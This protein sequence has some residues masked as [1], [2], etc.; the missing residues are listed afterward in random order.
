MEVDIE[1]LNVVDFPLDGSWDIFIFR[2]TPNF[3][4]SI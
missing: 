2:S 4:V 3:P 1:N